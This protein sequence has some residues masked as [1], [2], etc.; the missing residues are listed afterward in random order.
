M[1]RTISKSPINPS[2]S[3]SFSSKEKTN[4]KIT[5]DNSGK[6]VSSTYL[7]PTDIPNLSISQIT[8]LQ[9]ALDALAPV[10]S[11]PSALLNDILYYNGTE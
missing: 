1:F 6:V 5:Y 9:D 11:L 10:D 7:R 3:P 4:T 8:G 2:S